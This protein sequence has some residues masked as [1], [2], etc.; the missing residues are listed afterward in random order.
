MN[1]N[2]YAGSSYDLEMAPLRASAEHTPSGSRRHSN[3]DARRPTK[4]ASD[5]SIHTS[6]DDIPWASADDASWTDNDVTPKPFTTYP[7]SY[8]PASPLSATNSGRA[9]GLESASYDGRLAH[10]RHIVWP[11]VKGIVVESA[12]TLLLTTLGLLLTGELL[13]R[14]ARFPAMQR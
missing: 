7:E 6:S 10:I 12:P 8:D 11:Q 4:H 9:R 13:D 3:G 2:G 1:G 5:D 14:T